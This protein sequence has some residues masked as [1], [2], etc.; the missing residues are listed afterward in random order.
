MALTEGQIIEEQHC[1]N[2]FEC[3]TTHKVE[4]SCAGLFFKAQL[5]VGKVFKFSSQHEKNVRILKKKRSILELQIYILFAIISKEYHI[6][7]ITFFLD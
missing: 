7:K 6:P 1:L 3:H 4:V 5:K 2:I